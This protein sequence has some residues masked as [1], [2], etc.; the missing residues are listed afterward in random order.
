MASLYHD[1]FKS[2]KYRFN[3][4][5]KVTAFSE[6]SGCVLKNQPEKVIL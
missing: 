5:K 6:F 1:H 4:Y 2:P 3:V